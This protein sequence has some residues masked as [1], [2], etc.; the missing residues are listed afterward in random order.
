MNT[1][2][3]IISHTTADEPLPGHHKNHICIAVHPL[4]RREIN[5]VRL[6][7]FPR[8]SGSSRKSFVLFYYLLGKCT[9]LLLNCDEAS[10]AIIGEMT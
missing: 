6:F 3:T 1:I 4:F 7:I 8:T 10:V 2:V 5:L 9:S